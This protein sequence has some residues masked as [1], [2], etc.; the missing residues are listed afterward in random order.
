MHYALGDF[1]HRIGRDPIREVADMVSSLDDV[2]GGFMKKRME[3][4]SCSMANPNSSI[5]EASP[6]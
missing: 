6:R 4:E 5:V 3:M 1:V 2:S